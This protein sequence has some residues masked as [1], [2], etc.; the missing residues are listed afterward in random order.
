MI[1]LQ[2]AVRTAFKKSWKELPVLGVYLILTL[3]LLCPFSVLNIG[4][5]LIGGGRDGYQGLWNLW[6]VKRSTLSLSSPYVTD[7]L[8]YPYGADLYFHSLSSGAGFLTIPFQLAF[9]LVFTY[10]LIVILSFVLAGYGAYCLAHH[11]TGDKKA[12]FFGGLV[13]AFSAYHFARAL[14]HMN[15]VSVQ[16]IPF[17]VLFLLKMRQEKSFKNVFLAAAFLVLSGLTADLQYVFFLGMLTVFFVVYQSISSKE[18]FVE[19]LIRLGSM[20]AVSA[21]VLLLFLAPTVFGLF[22]GKYDYAISSPGD[23]VVLS[24]DLLAF[25]TP[26]SRNLFFGGLTGGV[27]SS[28]SSSPLFPIEGVAYVGYTVLA[29]AVYAAVKLKRSVRFW[30]LTALAFIVLSLGPMLHVMGSVSFT[31]FHV[32]IPLPELVLYYVF[33]VFRAPVRFIVMATLCLSVISA[34]AIK[35]ANMQIGK[36]KHGRILVLVFLIT[37]STA[38]M[39]ENNMLPYPTVEDT[40]VPEFYRTLAAMD[41]SFSVLDLPQTYQSNNRYMYYGTVSEKP[42][43]GGSISRSSPE[44]AMLQQAI[45][46]IRQTL[47]VLSGEN[48]TKATDIILQDVNLTNINSFKFFGV[49]YVVLHRDFMNSTCFRT[50]VSYLDS[51][52]GAPVYTD[53]RIVAYEVKAQTINGTF[54]FVA[55]GWWNLEEEDLVPTRWME[56]NAT[57]KV[58]SSSN[59]YC[60]LNF[61]VRTDYPGV[62][63]SVSLNGEWMG[64]IQLF[65][66][67]QETV[68]TQGFFRT[69]INELSFSAKQTVVPAEVNATSSDTRQLGVYIQN[70]EILPY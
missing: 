59:Q 54:A 55:S 25:L 43:V 28:F 53:E 2:N 24:A 23:S 3:I 69:G 62:V 29:L 44:N 27:I 14:E 37:L 34:I 22:S 5:S 9:G 31:V 68:I 46:L 63:L 45:P 38:F 33:P 19:F 58:Y 32:N 30:L 20:T 70:L 39:V 65:S 17:Y 48:L 40:S 7:H 12:S 11:I 61:T 1:R 26:N 52:M 50:M 15:L 10:N 36:L 18:G 67:E 49:K 41:G 6:W 56:R 57:V 64:N 47:N 4:S 8:Y 66:K 35:Q 60:T 16:W 42:L 21:G 13:F 51:L